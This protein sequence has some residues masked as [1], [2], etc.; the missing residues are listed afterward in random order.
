[1]EQGWKARHMLTGVLTWVPPLNAWRLHR[2]S[3]GGTDSPRY[4]YSVWLRH[5]VMLGRFGFR[6]KGTVIGELGPGDSIG[7]GLAALLSG[8]RTYTGLDIVP[9]SAKADLPSFCEE[10]LDMYVHRRPIPDDGEFPEVRP[11][12]RSYDFP[13]YLLDLTDIRDRAASVHD[14]LKAE[15]NHGTYLAYRAPWSSPNEIAPASLDL[16]FSQAV[17]EHVDDLER[18]Y[19]AMSLWLKPGGY[20]SHVIDFGAHGLSPYWNGH[21][22]YSDWE[23]RLV[24]GQREFLL[25]REPPSTHLAFAEEAGFEV[26]QLA[27]EYDRTGLDHHM[28]AKRFQSLDAENS[29][30]RGTVMILRKSC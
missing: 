6:V 15:I 16:I 25:N 13:E 9:F 5:L 22:S 11:K 19:Q 20:A 29:C 7:T 27:R 8:A 1:M 10:L 4:C 17:L 2:A 3:T 24:R 12:L 28:L 21:R 26:L 23:W 18:T 30:T 14:E